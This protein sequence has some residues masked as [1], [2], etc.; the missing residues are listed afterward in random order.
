MS[1]HLNIKNTLDILRLVSKGKDTPIREAYNKFNEETNEGKNMKKYSE[2][3]NNSI[4]SIISIKEESDIDSLFRSG[5]TTILI[6]DIKGLDDF[7]LLTF[8]VVI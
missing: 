3:L 5:G 6:N 7:E 2:L 1:S 8:M 4:N